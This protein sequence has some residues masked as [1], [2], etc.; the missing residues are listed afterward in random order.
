MLFGLDLGGS[1]L[2]GGGH[3]AK[4]DSSADFRGTSHSYSSGR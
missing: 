3:G 4:L 1:L 2:A